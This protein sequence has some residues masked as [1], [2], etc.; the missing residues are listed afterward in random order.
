MLRLI[1]FVFVL[2][3]VLSIIL[4]DKRKLVLIYENVDSTPSLLC[5]RYL[6]EH[7]EY[8]HKGLHRKFSFTQNQEVNSQFSFLSF[9][10]MIHRK[11]LR[12]WSHIFSSVVNHWLVTS[13]YPLIV[14]FPLIVTLFGLFF[15]SK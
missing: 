13:G 1:N 9:L 4:C 5:R 14:T 6:D 11:Q 7:I 10:E 2:G 3:S 15:I 8:D 12:N